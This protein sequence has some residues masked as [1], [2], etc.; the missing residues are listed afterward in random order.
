MGYGSWLHGEA[1]GTGMLMAADMSHR[2]NKLTQT[3]LERTHKL[4]AAAKLPVNTPA[5][6]NTDRF[7]ELMA[8]DKKVQAGVIRLVLLNHIGDSYV[9]D[10]Y[11]TNLL[12]ETIDAF[13]QAAN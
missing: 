13:H 6:M 5:E 1:V 12:R 7:L 8:V 10:D 2:Q 4:I 11:D 9:S 3:E